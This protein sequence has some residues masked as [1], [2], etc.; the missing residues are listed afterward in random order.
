MRGA[1]WRGTM[2]TIESVRARRVLD[3]RGNPTVE[4]DLH[5]AGGGFG[6]AIVPSGASTGIR[7][8]LELR[9][10]SEDRFGGKDV[11]KAVGNVQGAIVD[12]V[13][14]T[15]F[16]TQ[17][18]LD[19]ALIALDGTDNKSNL[20]ANAVLAVS[21]AFAHAVADEDDEPLYASLNGDATLLPLPLMNFLN[22]GAHADNNLDFQEIMVAPVGFDSFSEALRAGSEVFHALK[23]VLSQRGLSTNVGDEG[24]FAPQVDSN[25]A[26]LKLVVEGIE[27]A[28]YDAGSDVALALDVAAS[29][30]HTEAG[31]ELAGESRTLASGELDDFYAQL[32]DAYPIVSIEDGMD[33]GDWDGWAAHTKALGERV[34]LV[35]DDVFVTNPEI[36]QRGVDEGVA[37]AILLKVN[38]IGTLTETKRAQDLAVENGYGRVVSHRSGETEDATIA[39]LAVAWETGQIKTGSLSRSDRVAK[40]NE[41]IRIEERLGDRARYAGADGVVRG[42][43]R[44]A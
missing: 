23:K 37:N 34:Q 32:L 28:G 17:E 38:Q 44:A 33:E 8:A 6:R 36:L 35:G 26:A 24:G 22:G 7:E 11:T 5:L 14:G 29:E 42:A 18:D 9:D 20:G 31:Y 13:V 43:A 10:E 4:C 15:E 19:E 21:L 39:H 40:Y 30:F 16:A 1:G 27:A 3:S 12:A 41:L 25:E 2:A